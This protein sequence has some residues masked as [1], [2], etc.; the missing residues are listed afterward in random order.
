MSSKRI[1]QVILKI[2]Y[3]IAVVAAV[4]VAFIYWQ[5]R[6]N[7]VWLHQI[8]GYGERT[9]TYAWKQPILP[10]QFA[11]ASC[12]ACHRDELAQAPRLNHGR[13]LIAQYNC[14][15]CHRLQDIS[16]PAMLGPDLS[17]VGTKVSREWIYKWL[18]EPRTITDSD[19]NVLVDGVATRPKMPKFSLSDVEIRALSAYL[20]VQ[21]TK[22]IKSYAVNSRVVALVAKNG[23]AADQG[24]IRFNQMFCVTCH[25]LSVDRGGETSLIGGDIGPELTKVGSKVNPEWL[26][27]WLR[28]PKGYLAHTRMPQFQWSDK[29]LYVVTQYIMKRLNDPDL[30]KDVP[31][32]GAPT[33]AEIDLGRTLFVSKGCAECHVI[34]G[35]IAR[36]Q[37]GPD[38]SYLGMA[39]LP[40]EVKSGIAKNID[41][42][43]HFTHGVNDKIDVMVSRIPRF[44]I[45]NIESKITNPA[46]VTPNTHM[47][48]FSMS[49]KDVEDVTTALL[50]MVGPLPNRSMGES[51]VVPQVAAGFQP[52]GPFRDMYDRYKCI[53]CHSFKG[54]GGTLAP[55]L[56]YEGSR[57][58]REWLIQF[59]I[60]PQTL[61]PTLTV[62]MPEFNMSQQDATVI[63]DYLLQSLRSANVKSVAPLASSTAQDRAALGK[64]LFA[65]KY[66]CQSCHTIG[67]SGGYVG[68]SLNNAGNWLTPGWI[69][70]WL[71]D[72]QALVPGT[73]EPRHSFTEDEIQNLTAY[74]SSLKQEPDASAN[75]AGGQQ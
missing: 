29:D 36:E 67:S 35:V 28:D 61:R 59:L 65:D 55:D 75:T 71:R 14:V 50:S 68:P 20:S 60:K 27:A 45:A 57:A 74:L 4:F 17:S 49:Q 31:V 13:K 66:K 25:A 54:Y 7:Y 40:Y 1:R 32:M 53:D 39:P 46:S 3:A 34:S 11:Q 47:P 21:K 9:H 44:M 70:A 12:G 6:T 16:R 63:A 48:A 30:L 51:V 62:R 33:E 2:P 41:L 56:S 73:I 8:T 19:G 52:D 43:V 23:D 15:G 42:P 10:A 37:Y 58:Q 18:K 64:S 72:P 26:M 5:I 69:E 24:E 22:Q 38:L